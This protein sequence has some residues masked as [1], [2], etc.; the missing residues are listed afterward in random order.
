M[1]IDDK[2]ASEMTL[3]ER[4]ALELNAAIV[5]RSK[6]DHTSDQIEWNSMLACKMADALC[7][8]L[9]KPRPETTPTEPVT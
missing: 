4:A 7:R 9:A 2:P 8:E 5:I 1:K 6:H 3:R